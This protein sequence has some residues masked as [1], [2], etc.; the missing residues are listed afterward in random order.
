MQTLTPRQPIQEPTQ[1]ASGTPTR[2]VS[3]WPLITQPSARPCWVGRTRDETSVNTVP[4]NRPQNPP[5]I[6]PQAAT[7]RKLPPVATPTVAT[8]SP[9]GPP[10]R[11]GRVPQRSEPAP[12]KIEVMPQATEVMATRLAISGTLTE[13]SRAMSIRNGAR[14]VPLA[15]TVNI[16]SEAASSNAHGIR[17][18][19][20]N[21]A[22]AAFI[23]TTSWWL[24]RSIVPAWDPVA[25]SGYGMIGVSLRGGQRSI[26]CT[27][28][29]RRHEVPHPAA[30]IEPTVMTWS[31]LDVARNDGVTGRNGDT[32]RLEADGATSGLTRCRDTVR[33]PRP[34][35][36]K[37]QRR[38]RPR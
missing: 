8:A 19:S 25:G 32:R 4:L 10:I 21:G 24:L 20:A 17:S 7:A 35:R 28:R 18:R 26:D 15:A 38:C 31:S 36:H 37:Q 2:S 6:V 9:S 34:M 11:N 30:G 29:R 27:R 16:A 13:R 12:A 23:E 33:L 1:A 22:A 14:V 5:A 3:D